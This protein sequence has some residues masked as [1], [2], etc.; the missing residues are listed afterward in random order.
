MHRIRIILIA[1]LFI[2][3]FIIALLIGRSLI[4]TTSERTGPE[5]ASPEKEEIMEKKP[6]IYLYPQDEKDI[7]VSLNYKGKLTHTYPEFSKDTSWYVTAKPDGTL[8]C[9]GREYYALF[10]EGV[11]DN[12]YS[13]DEGF[14]IRGKETAKF[15]EEKLEILG[16]NPKEINEFIVYWLPQMENNPYNVIKFQGK[17]YTEDAQ[18]IVEPKE[19]SMIRVYMTW[20]PSDKAIKIKEQILT[21]PKRQGFAVVEWGGSKIK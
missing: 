2:I 6:L 7:K 18:L 16:L 1:V 17:D 14:C 21:S 11:K 20:Y 12:N 9:N 8:T 15:L 10:W 4:R 13:I 3:A 5:G 19:D